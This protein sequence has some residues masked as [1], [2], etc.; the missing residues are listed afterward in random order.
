MQ[1]LISDLNKSITEWIEIDAAACD[2]NSQLM[3][4]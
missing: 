2:A 1:K 4:C 3:L